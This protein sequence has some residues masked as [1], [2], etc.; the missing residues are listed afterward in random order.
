MIGR[1]S[2]H[3]LAKYK[4]ENQA[5]MKEFQNYFFRKIFN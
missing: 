2:Y 1:E 4:H 5:F 3:M